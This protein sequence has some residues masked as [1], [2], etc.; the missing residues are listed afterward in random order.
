MIWFG[1]F[2]SNAG[3]AELSRQ[4]VFALQDLGVN[5]AIQT[6]DPLVSPKGIL[7][8]PVIERLEEAV[9]ND[10]APSDC[11]VTTW[12]PTSFIKRG[13]H[14][15]GHTMFETD[16][17]PHKWVQHCNDMDEMWVPSE[18]NK[19]TFSASGVDESK[20]QVIPQGCDP[21]F[22]TPKAEP[23]NLGL[24]EDMFKFLSIFNWQLRKGWDVL[25]AAYY[26]EFSKRDDVVLILRCEDLV[27][28]QLREAVKGLKTVDSPQ[29]KVI[30]YPIPRAEMPGLYTGC[31]AFV[32]PS[33]G[34][35]W[36]LPYCEAMACELPVIATNWGGPTDYMTKDVAFLLEV[37]EDDPLLPID[38][39]MMEVT[40]AEE[41]HLWAN[42]SVDDLRAKMRLMYS[43]YHECKK[44]GKRA[45]ELIVNQYTWK[46]TAQ[47]ILERLEQLGA[48]I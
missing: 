44:V 26:M 10:D 13:V 38:E 47:R 17:I 37:D 46:H 28:T 41:N 22:Y 45:R 40:G 33:R 48:T 4:C 12:K 29:V 20:I 27:I 31:D 43:A 8:A 11:V 15:I 21:T 25:L 36:G 2:N 42:P 5:V 7:D 32:L 6:I 30:P 1:I 14:Q 23:M 3:Y 35:G 9:H 34:E 16:R 24:D 19:A 18:F 39:G